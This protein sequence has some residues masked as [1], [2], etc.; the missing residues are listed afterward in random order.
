MAVKR[1]ALNKVIKQIK[2]KMFKRQAFL[3]QRSKLI[4]GTYI[5]MAKMIEEDR[6]EIS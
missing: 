3:I 1:I 2:Y 6:S 4:Q 5:E